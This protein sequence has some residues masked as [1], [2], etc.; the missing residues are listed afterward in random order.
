MEKARCCR[1]EEFIAEPH[2]LSGRNKIIYARL[3]PERSVQIYMHR[4]THFAEG[5][6]KNLYEAIS[7]IH[8]G[9]IY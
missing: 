2:T 5:T 8:D 6:I 3:D 9:D 4:I 7:T 1:L